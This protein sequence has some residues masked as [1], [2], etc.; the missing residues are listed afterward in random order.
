MG[1]RNFE[2]GVSVE[3]LFDT[4]YYIDA[5]EFSNF[6][7]PLVTPQDD[8]VIGTLEQKRRVM[9]WVQYRF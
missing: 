1:W 3:N 4:D 2:F 9:G 6:A 5:Q 8:I 7:G